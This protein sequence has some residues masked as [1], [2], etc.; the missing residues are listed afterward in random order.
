MA[1][2]GCGG[3]GGGGA[4]DY[5]GDEKEIAKNRRLNANLKDDY[6]KQ[7]QVMKLLLLGPGE[8]GKSTVF[9]QVNALFN[10]GY[11]EEERKKHRTIVFNNLYIGLR[12]L[13][14]ESDKLADENI[15]HGTR[16]VS[17]EAL[18][19]REVI[20]KVDYHDDLTLSIM[21][22]LLALWND[23]GIQR[24]WENRARFQCPYPLDYFMGKIQVLV[25]PD[26]IPSQEDVLRCRVRTTGIVEKE[27]TIEPNRFLIIDVGGQRNERKKWMHCFDKVTAVLFVAA[28]SEYDQTLY[29]DQK[30]NR[31]QEGLDLFAEVSGLKTFSNT[32]IILFLNKIDLFT[33]KIKKGVPLKDCFEDYSGSGD[34]KIAL[35][36]MK[37]KF[38]S[39]AH[40]GKKIFAHFTCATDS[41]L[42][43][44]VLLDVRDIIIQR[45]VGDQDLVD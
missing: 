44:N 36:F 2:C 41:D 37:D 8:S 15:V 9:K 32:S 21:N 27:F 22:H 29:E 18:I 7:S 6:L 34:E 24:T 11:P 14:Q 17:D 25:K 5:G 43:R 20:D 45:G 26:Y 42:I 1:C 35:Q 23:K 4:G 40:P 38:L 10:N 31:V 16:I 30:T 39:R 19:A 3:P 28:I 13:I 12:T 33:E